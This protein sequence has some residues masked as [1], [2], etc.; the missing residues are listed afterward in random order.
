[1]IT[2]FTPVYNRA[3]IINNLYESLKK[4]TYK[5]F[6]WLIVNDGSS[7]NID[8][9]V[10]TF[11]NDGVINIRF[12]SQVNGG[13]H[14][15][16]NK[17]VSLAQGDLFFIVD[18]DDT[19]TPNA[20]EL[21]QQYYDQIKDNDDFAGVSGYR[22]DTRGE[23]VYN[24][25]IKEVLDCSSIEYS[26]QFNQKGGLAESFKTKVLKEY[27]F[28]DF[29]GETFCA[30]SLVWN[31][32]ASKRKLRIFAEDIYVWNYLD[33]GLTKGSIK[34]RMRCPTY[35]TT[36]YSELLDAAIPVKRKIKSAINYW[37]FYWCESSNIKPRIAYKWFVFSL[38][39]YILH[40]NDKRSK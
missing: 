18:S 17:G 2:V 5:D 15:A 13:K 1:M 32:I 7:D 19:I 3:Y 38:L 28:P 9:I 25:K 33:D 12:Y 34:N 22:C 24:F 35:A 8:E 21:L 37:R 30:E 16:I 40:L 11:I 6:E 39:G 20:L 29:P 36:I 27:P 31:R 4:Q 10:Q 26:N 14:R 23:N